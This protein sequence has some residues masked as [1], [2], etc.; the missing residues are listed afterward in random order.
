MAP[1]AM[2]TG[3]VLLQVRRVCVTCQA[4]ATDHWFTLIYH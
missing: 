3:R 1:S 4:C 2:H